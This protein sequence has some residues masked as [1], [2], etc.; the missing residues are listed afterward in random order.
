MLHHFKYFLYTVSRLSDW[1]VKTMALNATQIN[2][3]HSWLLLWLR[4][5]TA[6]L[7]MY[8]LARFKVLV[9]DLMCTY[10]L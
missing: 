6:K 4:T 7:V 5:A 10:K 1:N 2:W 9:M 8:I 3:K